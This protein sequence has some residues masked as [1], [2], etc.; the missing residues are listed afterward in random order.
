M[1]ENISNKSNKPEERQNALLAF[2]KANGSSS[3]GQVF[4]YARKNFGKITRL[5][6]FRDLDKL[7]EFNLIERQGESRRTAIYRMS[8]QYSVFK[9]IDVKKYFTTEPDQRKIREKFNFDIFSQLKNIFTDSENEKLTEL[10]EIYRKKIENIAPDALRK[11]IER[12]TIDF[13]WKSSKIEGNTY[14]LLETEELIKNQQEASGRTKEEAVMIINHKKTL[15]YIGSNKEKFET[16]F[17]AQIEDIHSLLVDGLNVTKNLRK[18]LVGITGTKYRPPD[19]EFQIREALEK[20]CVLINGTKNIFEKAVILMLLIAYIQPFVD[21][22]KRTSRLS[23]NAILQS[24][25]SCPLS[26]RSMDE[27]EYKKAVLLFFEQNNVS[28][29]KELFLKQFE[30]AVNNYF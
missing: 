29:F 12:L 22:N 2:I 13:S 10:D 23:G 14:S 4:E 27:M 8:P 11:E 5:T 25:G 20:T 16:I 9:K 7:R 24:F 6:V 19:N 17:I 18:T 3:I 28:Y 21:G 1:T 26:Y 15:D 30:F